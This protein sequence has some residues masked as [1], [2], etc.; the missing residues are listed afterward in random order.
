MELQLAGV[1]EFPARETPLSDAGISDCALIGIY[2]AGG[3]LPR[4][5]KN[6]NVSALRIA[7]WKSGRRDVAGRSSHTRQRRSSLR[8][9][10][11]AAI[12]SGSGRSDPYSPCGIRCKVIDRATLRVSI[13][14]GCFAPMEHPPLPSPSPITLSFPPGGHGGATF[15]TS[16]TNPHRTREA[17]DWHSIP[18]L[19]YH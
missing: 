19:V 10:R 5:F 4:F 7:G 12:S 9:P 8:M 6:P 15:V 2:C 11:Y 17:W 1:I 3:T 16:S 18:H 13:S 14:L